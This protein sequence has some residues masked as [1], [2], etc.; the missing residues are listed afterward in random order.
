MVLNVVVTRENAAEEMR[1]LWIG[2]EG[3]AVASRFVCFVVVVG[4]AVWPPG[5]VGV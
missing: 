2:G 1:N 3:F 5:G 4:V